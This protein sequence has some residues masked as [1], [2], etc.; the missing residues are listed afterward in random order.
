MFGK[1]WQGQVLYDR[2]RLLLSCPLKEPAASQCPPVPGRLCGDLA[3]PVDHG[4]LP[5]GEGA[6][7]GRGCWELEV[8]FGVGTPGFQIPIVICLT[9]LAFLFFFFFPFYI[10]GAGG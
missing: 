8:S 2:H 1:V 5:A 6:G 3:L 4:V 9:L 10:F 7:K